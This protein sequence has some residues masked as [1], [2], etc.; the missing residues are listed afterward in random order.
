[1]RP[2][3][4]RTLPFVLLAALCISSIRAPAGQSTFSN[5]AYQQSLRAAGKLRSDGDFQ[6]AV[7][8]YKNAIQISVGTD[9]AAYWGLAQ[10]Y[11]ELHEENNVLETCAKMIAVAPNDAIRALCHNLNGMALTPPGISDPAVLANAEKE[12]RTALQLDSG[13]AAIHFS[14]GF[15]LLAGGREAEGIEE[16]KAYLRADEDGPYSEDAERFV[17]NPGKGRQMVLE[18]IRALDDNSEDD[19]HIPLGNPAPDFS[20]VSTHGDR[21]SLASLRGKVILLEFWASWCGPCKAAFPAL[22]QIYQQTDKTKVVMLSISED[23]SEV[24]WRDFLEKNQPSW[25][26][27]RDSNLKV[28]SPFYQN[29]GKCPLPG[30]FLLDTSGHIRDH[31]AGWSAIQGVRLQEEIIELVNGTLP[32]PSRNPK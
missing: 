25:T 14:L 19:H 23:E 10:T 20:V 8:E 2:V 9:Y 24:E 32:P 26:Q 17:A 7:A 6:K 3:I 11:Y 29:S 18:T 16:M 5:S 30:Y 22:E 13:Y 27:A 31:T 4:R 15:A 1:M 12:F 21:I 28:V